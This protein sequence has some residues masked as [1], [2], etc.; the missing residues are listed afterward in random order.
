MLD[1]FDFSLEMLDAA[2]CREFWRGLFHPAGAGCPYCHTSLTDVQAESWRD[3]GKVHCQSCGRWFTWRSLTHLDNRCLDERQLTLLC[4][5]IKYKRSI[6]EICDK[7]GVSADTV[8]R[9]RQR[10][11]VAA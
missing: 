9:W 6:T 4:V 5:M 7:V 10:L 3:G 11:R 2:A 8:N 1:D